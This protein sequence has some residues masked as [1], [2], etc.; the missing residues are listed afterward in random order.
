MWNKCDWVLFPFMI[1]DCN[2]APFSGK[3]AHAHTQQSNAKSNK[4]DIIV[5]V[6][7]LRMFLA[8]NCDCNHLLWANVRIISQCRMSNR[9]Q[10]FNIFNWFALARKV[11]ALILNQFLSE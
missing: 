10:D 2:D 3:W 7:E 6:C 8:I 4:S 11:F 9:H 1:T 5:S